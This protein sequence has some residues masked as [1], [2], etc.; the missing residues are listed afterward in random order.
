MRPP[1]LVIGRKEIEKGAGPCKG[2]RRG[3]T[4]LSR[5]KGGTMLYFVPRPSTSA[6]APT[7]SLRS[8]ALA[9]QPPSPVGKLAE[10][11]EPSTS[12]LQ[13]SCSSS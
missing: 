11:F 10:G 9:A 8:F 12:C 3:R 1:S 4:P 7:E 5:E 2:Y 6:L 13:S